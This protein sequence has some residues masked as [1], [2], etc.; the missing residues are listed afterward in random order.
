MLV[1]SALLFATVG[2]T[3]LDIP[4][5][6]GCD[7]EYPRFTATFPYDEAHYGRRR[8]H[9]LT[10][11][12]IDRRQR[13]CETLRQIEGHN[14]LARAGN[15]TWSQGINQFADWSADE[16]ATYAT[17]GLKFDG[18]E[19]DNLPLFEQP[20]EYKLGAAADFRSKMPPA[21]NQVNSRPETSRLV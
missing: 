16:L 21:K 15:S 19:Q 7:I 18:Q 4:T 11:T 10:G 17:S 8:T 9:D 1:W 3:N 2:A 13:F 14:A 5:Y 12:K 6:E 20:K